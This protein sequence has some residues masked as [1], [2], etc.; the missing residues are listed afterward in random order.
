[1]YVPFKTDGRVT[2]I[3]LKKTKNRRILTEIRCIVTVRNFS[4]RFLVFDPH[5]MEPLPIFNQ[6]HDC[7]QALDVWQNEKRRHSPKT[8]VETKK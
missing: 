6:I 3:L 1:M 4:L 5:I 7:H 2:S 8:N